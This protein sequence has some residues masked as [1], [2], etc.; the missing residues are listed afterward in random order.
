MTNAHARLG[1]ALAILWISVA[2]AANELELG[3]G[4]KEGRWV[5]VERH[6]KAPVVGVLETQ[7]KSMLVVRIESGHLKPIPNAEVDRVRLIYPNDV[8][9]ETARAET[10]RVTLEE[11]LSATRPKPKFPWEKEAAQ[12]PQPK[13]DAAPAAEPAKQK[14]AGRDYIASSQPPEPPKR[15]YR[16]RQEVLR[17]FIPPFPQGRRSASRSSVPPVQRRDYQRG[18]P[19]QNTC[20][21]NTD[22]RRQ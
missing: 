22:A 3:E 4:V 7:L 2:A 6:E 9:V 21:N 1:V 16:P 14:Q 18:V 10:I 15:T 20:I 12:K 19:F 13:Q 5:V 17:V 11:A 8:T